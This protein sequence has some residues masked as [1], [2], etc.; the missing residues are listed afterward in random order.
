MYVNGRQVGRKAI[1]IRTSVRKRIVL[2]YVKMGRYSKSK[3][4]SR[5]V[6]FNK[7]DAWINISVQVNLTKG[8]IAS[9][10]YI[11]DKW[12]RRETNCKECNKVALI[13]RQTISRKSATFLGEGGE[14]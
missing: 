4:A 13:G 10:I 2:K 12:T 5:N 3:G 1:Y 14:G 8:K 7:L 11:M 9:A 6:L